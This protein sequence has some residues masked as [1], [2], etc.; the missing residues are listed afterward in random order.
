MALRISRVLCEFS[1]VLACWEPGHGA[2]DTPT[3]RR[4][5]R[6]NSTFPCSGAYVIDLPR[7]LFQ[8]VSKER[9]SEVRGAERRPGILAPARGLVPS[10]FDSRAHFYKPF[11]QCTLA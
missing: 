1:V 2:P 3:H 11:G 8:T 7:S 9:F 5:D 6:S 10:L 4:I